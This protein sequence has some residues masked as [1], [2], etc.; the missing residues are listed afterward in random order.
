MNLYPV[1]VI[2][3]FYENPDAI[4]EFALAQ[5]YKYRHEEPDS[6]Q[7]VYPGCRTKDIFDLDKS[8]QE[9]VLKKLVSVFH[10]PEH[11]YMQWAISTSFQSVSEAYGRGVIHTDNN[12]IFAGVIYLTPNAPLNSGTSIYRTNKTF[13]QEAYKLASDQNDAR[14]KTGEIVMDTSFHSMFDE[15]ITINNVYNTLIIF[16]GDIFHSANNFFGTTLNDSRLAQV[17]FISKIN[18]NKANSFPLNRTKAIKL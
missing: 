17:F 2:D 3:N 6:L 5:Q 7:Y 1:T 9:K 8:L 15:V 18:A 12:I 16:E 13:T 14:F 11:D 4:R 10:I